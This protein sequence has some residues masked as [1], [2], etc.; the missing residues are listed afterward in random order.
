MIRVGIVGATGYTGIE[1][2]R[3]LKKHPSAKIVYMSSRTYAG[4]KMMEVYP[5]TLEE[6]VLEDFDSRKISESC[7]VVFTALPAGVSYR[8]AMELQNVKI[9]DLGAD[10]R[11]DDPNTYA[12]WY[13]NKL[14]DYNSTER[15][16]GLPELYRDSIKTP[17]LWETRGV[18]LRA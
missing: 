11:F 15:V 13:G 10:F 14:E 18:T 7:D 1:L 9:I 12:E 4:K 8:L 17:E 2:F 6:A 5:S 16:Y 3:L